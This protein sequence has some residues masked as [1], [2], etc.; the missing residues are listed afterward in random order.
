[1]MEGNPCYK[2]RTKAKDSPQEHAPVMCLEGANNSHGSHGRVHG[3]LFKSLNDYREK[4]QKSTIPFHNPGKSSNGEE[5]PSALKHALNSVT[6]P[7]KIG[8]ASH[9][10]KKCLRAQLE[11]YYKACKDKEVKAVSG[12]TKKNE[13]QIGIREKDDEG[14]FDNE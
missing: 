5:K 12:S 10:S 9:C 4:T 3:A 11:A 13:D 2:G 8:P 1:M 7:L 14:G 6:K